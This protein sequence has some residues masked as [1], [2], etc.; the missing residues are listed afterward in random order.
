MREN[1]YIAKTLHGLED[2]LAEELKAIKAKNIEKGNRSVFFAGDA[3]T[4]YTANYRLRTAIRIIESFYKFTFNNIDDFYKNIYNLPWET[5]VSENSS[6]AVDAS[7]FNSKLFNNSHFTELKAKDAIVDYFRKKTGKRPFV[8]KENPNLLVNIFVQGN[9]CHVS[10]DTSGIPLYKRSYRLSLHEA[11]LNEVLASGLI[12]LSEWN[13]KGCFYDPMCGSGTIPIEAAMI[14]HNIPAGYFRK[15]YGFMNWKFFDRNL[16]EKIV[17]ENQ[18]KDIVNDCHIYA[19]DSAAQSIHFTR[20]NLAHARLM[21]KIAIEKISFENLKPKQETGILIFNPPYNKRQPL[22]NAREFY[23]NIGDI[24]KNNFKNHVAWIIS[25]DKD[26][27]KFIGLKPSKKI[28]LFNGPLES[29]FCK[30]ECY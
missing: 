28:T 2:V 1:N 6:I 15:S 12:L 22:E 3:K 24:L 10:L 8:D 21:K 11:S 18:P 5:I 25:G 19:S 30:Y 17:E 9:F 16:W 7:V 26:I 20:K 14:A 4:M 27:I 29:R 13:K 23:K